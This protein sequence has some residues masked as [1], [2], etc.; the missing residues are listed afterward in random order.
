MAT[1][2]ADLAALPPLTGS[3]VLDPWRIRYRLLLTGQHQPG[4]ARQ[5]TRSEAVLWEALVTADADWKREHWTGPYYRLDFFLPAV[6]LAVEVDGPSHWGRDGAQR[7][8]LRDAWHSARG[9]RTL[10]VSDREVLS[11][12]PGVLVLI[13]QEVKARLLA[14]AAPIVAGPVLADEVVVLTKVAT[15]VEAEVVRLARACETVLPAR[16]DLLR[17]MLREP[18]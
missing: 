3:P 7:D 12:L 17:R 13:A 2:T 14:E 8:A 18:L 15:A 11:D 16:K 4:P 1:P 9:I 10:R 5:Q 6:R